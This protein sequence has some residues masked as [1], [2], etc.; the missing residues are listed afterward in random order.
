MYVLTTGCAWRHLPLG[1][2]VSRA[3][4][5]RRFT[6]W[7]GAG[8]WRRLQ[9]AALNQLGAQG[10]VDWSPAAAANARAKG[11]T[12]TGPKPS[13]QPLPTRPPPTTPGQ[14]ARRQRLRL[15]PPTAHAPPA[16]HLTPASPDAAS[17]PRTF[18]AGT[19]GSSNGPS[20]GSPATTG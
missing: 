18:S 19:A 6:A 11:V 12:L 1:F 14:A 2:G 5:H 17:N 7:T 15:P 13:S 10:L 9:V 16:V 20:P 3:T 8:L 4:A